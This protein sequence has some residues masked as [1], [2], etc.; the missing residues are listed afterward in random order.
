M[1]TVGILGNILV[2]YITHCR[3]KGTLFTFFINVLAWLDLTNLML[4]MPTLLAITVNDQSP[5]F[6]A[7]CGF[8]TFVALVTG[9][10]S[11]VFL[12][13]IAADR[14]RKLC[15]T[16]KRQIQL[17]LARSLST[18][19]ILLGLALSIPGLWVF[20]R[21]TVTFTGDVHPVSISYCFVRN[22]ANSTLL[23]SWIVILGVLF[24]AI[25]TSL[26]VLYGFTVLA[27]R[28]NFRRVSMAR[29]PSQASISSK[30]VSR[31]HAKVF[32]A[33]TVVFFASYAPYL[34][35]V[36]LSVTNTSGRFDM[37]AVAKAFFDFAKLIPLLS[38]TANPAIYSLTSQRFR[39]ECSKLFTHLPCRQMLSV[40]RKDSTTVSELSNHSE[41]G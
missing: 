12:V 11:A 4:A 41:S 1:T 39:Q 8:T 5:H 17:P 14:F 30:R 13:V 36:V 19:C 40:Q 23:I 28:K 25:S 34:V 18:A 27:L 3:W 32:I 26:L 10:S 7:A 24:M 22:D 20:G 2:L 16:H 6:T 33:V 35:T 31:K 21:N 38:N 9:F 15:Q 29:R 37:G